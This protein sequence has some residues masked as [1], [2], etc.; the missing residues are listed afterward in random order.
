VAGTPLFEAD[1]YVIKFHNL[2]TIDA[3]DGYACSLRIRSIALT[4]LSPR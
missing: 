1:R 4:C 3:P 2:W